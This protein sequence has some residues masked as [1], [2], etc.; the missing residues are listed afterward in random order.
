MN[1]KQDIGLRRERERLKQLSARL[2]N[3]QEE[4]R[5]RLARELHDEIG[6]ALTAV[7]INLQ[8]VQRLPQASSFASRLEESI[9]IIDRT[10]QQVRDLSLDLRP[11]LLDDLG[12]V[13]ALR[14]HIERQ[15]QRAGFTVEF[16][17]G[18]L[19]P[20]PTPEIE[21]ACF[22]VVQ[23]ALTNV[24]RH[25][26]AQHVWIALHVD[27]NLL[28]VS[29]QDDGVGFDVRQAL[30][31]AARGDSLGLIGMQERVA[32]VGGRLTIEA[33]PGFGAKI[34]ARFPLQMV[35]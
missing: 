30:E 28:H 12:L 1:E 24:A 35:R 5:R 14:W 10:L 4:E 13:S 21:V 7:K 25:A 9:G 15:A 22:R 27:N 26:H 6:Q 2:V 8:T 20:R 18:L 16:D 32:L 23:E 33:A 34:R 19:D 17:A 31:Q 11:P 29:V 3:A